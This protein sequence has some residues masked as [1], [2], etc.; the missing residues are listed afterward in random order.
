MKFYVGQSVKFKEW[1]EMVEQYGVR[2]DGVIKC[3]A[4]FIPPMRHLCGQTGY[5]LIARE[6]SYVVGDENGKCFHNGWTISGHMLKETS[7]LEKFN[8]E[9]LLI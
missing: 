3:D 6:N 7:E 9:E 5:I 1:D 4:T 2:G 8:Y